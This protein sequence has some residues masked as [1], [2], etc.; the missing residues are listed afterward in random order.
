MPREFLCLVEP[1]GTVF[2]LGE[3]TRS[4]Y[5]RNKNGKK[6]TN[7]KS[8]WET[9]KFNHEINR[10]LGLGCRPFLGAFTLSSKHVSVHCALEP[11]GRILSA[12]FTC[13]LDKCE[14]EKKAN[15]QSTSF[16]FHL[17]NDKNISFLCLFARIELQSNCAVDWIAQVDCRFF[18]YNILVNALLTWHSDDGMAKPEEE[19]GEKR[20]KNERTN[21]VSLG[22]LFMF[23]PAFFDSFR[24][25]LI[26]IQQNEIASRRRFT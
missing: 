19:E 23:S 18:N 3:I 20:L 11:F 1:V 14:K 13:D 9:I 25:R 12:F 22:I 5:W 21:D 10:A 8:S 6:N 26:G 7:T 17:N 2:I 15:R 16:Y 4:I 24:A